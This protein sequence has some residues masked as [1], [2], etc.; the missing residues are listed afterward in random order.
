MVAHNPK[1]RWSA[2]KVLEEIIKEQNVLFTKKLAEIE[3]FHKELEEYITTNNEKKAI[4]LIKNVNISWSAVLFLHH[5][6]RKRS[7]ALFFLILIPFSFS[8]QGPVPFS[9]TRCRFQTKVKL[10]DKNRSTRLHCNIFSCTSADFLRVTRE[11]P[12]FCT[13][14]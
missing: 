7:S 13:N 6:P 3:K 11:L 10:L 9:R 2:E 4:E 1:E 5:D 8:F 14:F 12:W